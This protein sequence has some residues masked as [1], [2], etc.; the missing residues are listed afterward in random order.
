ME[1]EL[2]GKARKE[3]NII[4][5]KVI[6]DIMK[7][8]PLDYFKVKYELE[9]LGP[10]MLRKQAIMQERKKLYR[11]V[12]NPEIEEH[13]KLHEERLRI[14]SNVKQAYK[15]Q[16]ERH[17]HHIPVKSIFYQRVI[18]RDQKQQIKQLQQ[19][20]KKQELIMRRK[21]YGE[22]VK[23]FINNPD[24]SDYDEENEEEVYR[25][26]SASQHQPPSGREYERNR[27]PSRHKSFESNNKDQESM[28]KTVRHRKLL[29]D[30]LGY[31]SLIP[32]PSAHAERSVED[33]RST[34]SKYLSLNNVQKDPFR[35]YNRDIKSEYKSQYVRHSSDEGGQGGKNQDAKRPE[36]PAAADPYSRSKKILKR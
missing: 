20:K 2:K 3:T 11:P 7:S 25:E 17:Q 24:L 1:F 4:S 8:Q 35:G 30:N 14:L 29:Y 21:K 10:E 13:N 33:N 15:A 19:A 34:K 28:G 26:P 12:R 6:K 31:G 5:D 36:R 18:K 27:D 23:Q 32:Q 16:E 22:Y 9:V